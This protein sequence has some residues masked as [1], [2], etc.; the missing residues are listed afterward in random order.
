MAAL[1]VY[2]NPT[3]GGQAY[4]EVTGFSSGEAVNISLHDVLG[5][6]VASVDAVAD[7]RGYAHI[8]VPGLGQL[9]QGMY[10]IRASAQSGKAQTKLL[11]Q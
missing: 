10:I 4:A 2:P 9:K 8:E 1:R 3:S 11:V 6:V 5:R 7:Q